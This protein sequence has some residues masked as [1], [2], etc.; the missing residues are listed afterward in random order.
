LRGRIKCSAILNYIIFLIVG[1]RSKIQK[2]LVDLLTHAGPTCSFYPSPI[3]VVPMI[4]SLVSSPPVVV[5]EFG[6]CSVLSEIIVRV[7]EN[8]VEC[9]QHDYDVDMCISIAECH[10]VY[11]N[12]VLNGSIIVPGYHVWYKNVI[13]AIAYIDIVFGKNYNYAKNHF[14]NTH[15]N[16]GKLSFG[17]ESPLEVAFNVSRSSIFIL[18]KF[19]LSHPH[20][21]HAYEERPNRWS[22]V[23]YA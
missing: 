11:Y 21:L 12:A 18:S 5:S 19:N 23:S 6:E 9:C 8:S 7:S 14:F 15:I 16:D 17:H 13:C 4:P 3:C 1:V 22:Y 20:R 2:I 10:Q